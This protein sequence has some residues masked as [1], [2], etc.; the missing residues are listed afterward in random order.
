MY[1][2]FKHLHSYLAYLLLALLLFAILY[3]AYCWIAKKPFLKSNRI[4]A[5][6]GLIAAHTQ[7][8]AGLILYFLSPV[9]F[10]NLSGDAMKN[11]MSRLYVLE[12]PLIMLIAVVLVTIGYSKA[13]RLTVD[14]K[15]YRTIVIFYLIGLLLMLSRIPWQAWL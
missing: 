1:T 5:L 13:K 7:F 12:H 2:G 10:T 9:G 15:K 14:S 11:S 3:T 6:L 4:V 8:L